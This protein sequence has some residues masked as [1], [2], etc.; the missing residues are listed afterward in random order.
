MP[1]TINPSR[2]VQYIDHD[3]IKKLYMLQKAQ[4]CETCE[5]CEPIPSRKAIA[6]LNEY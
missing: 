5:T 3:K 1:A 6:L 4:T 2:T